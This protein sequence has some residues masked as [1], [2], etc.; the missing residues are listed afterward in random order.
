MIIQRLTI[1]NFRPFYGE[2]IIDFSERDDKRVTLIHA[3]NGVGKSAILS[4]IL[5]CLYERVIEGFGQPR[6]LMNWAAKA[7]GKNEFSV[8]LEFEY[9]GKEYA[10]E[11]KGYTKGTANYSSSALAHEIDQGNWIPIKNAYNFINQVVPSSMADYFFFHGEGNINAKG[12]DIERAIRDILGFE[13]AETAME[14]LEALKT[15]IRRDIRAKSS[16]KNVQHIQDEL[17]KYSELR[18]SQKEE[19]KQM[20]PEE[21]AYDAK[22]SDL[23]S[24]LRDQPDIRKT[25][26][27]REK[28][29]RRLKSAEAGLVSWRERE[30]KF[31]SKFGWALM[32]ESLANES[33]DFIDDRE[34][35]GKIPSPYNETF[36]DDLLSKMVCICGTK[37]EEGSEA[38]SKVHAML[39]SAGNAELYHRIGKARARITEI[40]ISAN[41]APDEWKRS[42][43]NLVKQKELVRQSEQRISELTS[44]IEA[45]NEKKILDF[46]RD[47]Q[48]SRARQRELMQKLGACRTRLKLFNE[49]INKLEK[50]AK[51][52]VSKDIVTAKLNEKLN[53]VQSLID[54]LST[55]LEGAQDKAIE[56][57]GA[58]INDTLRE[59]SRKNYEAQ[60]DR[61]SKT[62]IYRNVEGNVVGASTGEK[63]LL[64]FAFISTLISFC[65][66]RQDDDSQFLIPGAIAPFVI[67][68][69]FGELD[70]EYKSATAAFLPKK[71]RQVILL[72]STSHWSGVKETLE[73]HIGM[74]YYLRSEN[75]EER[76]GKPED[77]LELN[78]KKVSQSKYECSRDMTRVMEVDW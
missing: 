20:L 57:I 62:L 14:D 10:V 70:S 46:E 19:L 60:I 41:T 17:I 3:E 16:D 55:E 66:E 40:R 48:D 4:S 6:D 63:L 59:I 31:I 33:T 28:E 27:E 15:S 9:E 36:I 7:E 37:L 35:K 67:D 38:Y 73:E 69:P 54:I 2:Q 58:E 29:Q 44:Q 51:A 77:L 22:I 43:T 56:Q 32:A 68:A 72:L 50:E 53:F 25:Q 12:K 21:G 74:E 1:R 65:R 30:T 23:E 26:Q 45:C 47:L 64:N 8:Q 13:I 49:Q 78:G 75:K 42:Q 24:K 11:R 39:A 76:A 71:S 34:I 61:E 5:W 52:A 18:D